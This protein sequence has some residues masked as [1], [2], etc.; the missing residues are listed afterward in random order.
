METIN[1]DGK[2]NKYGVNAS[3]NNNTVSKISCSYSEKDDNL[4]WITIAYGDNIIKG[5]KNGGYVLNQ[6][7]GG[8]KFVLSVVPYT[9]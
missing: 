4:G 9:M 5:T 8:N 7:T 1:T 6:Y 2:K 3:Y